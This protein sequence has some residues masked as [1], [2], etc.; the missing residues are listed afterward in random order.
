[1]RTDDSVSIL[2]HAAAVSQSAPDC[3]KPL[4]RFLRFTREA[5]LS[6]RVLP[7]PPRILVLTEIS[8][9]PAISP[10]W[11]G[12]LSEVLSLQRRPLNLHSRFGRFVSALK[13]PFPRNSSLE[14]S[15]SRRLGALEKSALASELSPGHGGAIVSSAPGAT[16]EFVL[17]PSCLVFQFRGCRHRRCVRHRSC[18]GQN[19]R[20]PGPARVHRRSRRGSA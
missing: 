8:R 12:L 16:A 17:A 5:S 7:A 2:T 18:R 19:V 14:E 4:R 9:N 20:A 13:I 6:D 1:M 15:R 11:A 10:E 3:R